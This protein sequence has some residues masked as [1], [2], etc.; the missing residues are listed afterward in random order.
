ME[1]LGG[2]VMF[3][4]V[5]F[6]VDGFNLY[7]S[8]DEA[9]ADMGGIGT[10]WLD[11]VAVCEA[12][13]YP[14]GG[15]AR[16]ESVFYFSAPANHVE[17][18]KPG[19]IERHNT[20]VKALRSRG[21]QVEMGKFKEKWRTCPSC[22]API[23]THE[24]KET[25][26]AIAVRLMELLWNDRC[27]VAVIVSAD[28]DLSPAIREAKRSFPSKP[29]Y[30]CFPYGRGSLELRSLAKACFRIRKERYAKHQLPDPVVLA[31]G[32]KLAKPAGW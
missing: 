23:T 8:L 1:G 20:L 17:Q 15:G 28:S 14:I 22:N 32:T 29:I 9:S 21:V 31:D 4:R 13:L 24:E 16:I 18:A 7:H 11:L 25:D 5:A 6:L 26:V 10:K 27:E 30:C 2:V 3:R 12:F 19:A